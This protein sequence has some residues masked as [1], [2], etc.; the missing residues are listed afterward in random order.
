[1]SW[2]GSERVG[3]ETAIGVEKKKKHSIP[4][5][6]QQLCLRHEALWI[7]FSLY[8]LLLKDEYF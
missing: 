7:C 5:Y 6:L 4:T 8:F 2:H 1:M 3:G